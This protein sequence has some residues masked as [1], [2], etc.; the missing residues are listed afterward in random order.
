MQY[1]NA[2]WKRKAIID[3]YN[4]LIWISWNLR[5][6]GIFHFHWSHELNQI[7]VIPRDI[8]RSCVHFQSFSMNFISVYILFVY[9]GIFVHKI[10][11]ISI[12]LNSPLF[13]VKISGCQ[14]VANEWEQSKLHRITLLREIVLAIECKYEEVKSKQFWW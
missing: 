14:A 8:R 9:Q 1:F 3:N 13:F 11:L 2:E 12:A 5:L 10:A 7:D 4:E 6:I